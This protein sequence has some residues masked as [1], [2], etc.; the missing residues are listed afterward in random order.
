MKNF[1]IDGYIEKTEKYNEKIIDFEKDDAI[2][3]FAGPLM[4]SL[5]S[6]D[7]KTGNYYEYFENDCLFE[8][9][10]ADELSKEEIQKLFLEEQTE[11][12]SLLQRKLR[13]ITGYGIT[14]PIFK[15]TIYDKENNIL[16]STGFISGESITYH[17]YDYTEEKKAKLNNRLYL[18]IS[19]ATI[20]DL[21]IKNN[22]FQ[23]ALY[24]YEKSFDSFD[25]GVRF[26]MLFT[27]LESL[28]NFGL[29]ES[30]TEEI[31][32]YAS[33]ILFLPK[34]KS[35]SSK[36]KLITYYKIR[37]KYIHGND[38][39]KITENIETNLREY[40][41]ETLLIY[42]YISVVYHVNEP[43]QIK[44]LLTNLNNNNLDI[45]VQLFIKYLRTPPTNYHILFSKIKT[46]FLNN[47]FQ[48]L[49]NKD[50]D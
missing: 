46:N 27:A 18:Y 31:S 48:I 37:S 6:C 26:T 13:L 35:K 19:D 1:K 7:E 28:F 47:N 43:Q 40:V 14:L 33:K 3:Y 36:W 34:N 22:R 24:F 29:K 25:N 11:K 21:E 44:E 17:V 8:K 50:L 9:K 30:I 38:G 42:W 45:Q 2:F 39:F 41:R 12:I 16:T 10:V 20:K 23:R 4:D 49:N 15:I 32:N 5:Y